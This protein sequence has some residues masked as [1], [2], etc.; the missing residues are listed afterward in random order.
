MG[1]LRFGHPEDKAAA[2]AFYRRQRS[3]DSLVANIVR[4]YMQY[5]L[6]DDWPTKSAPHCFYPKSF[7]RVPL[8]L[9]QSAAEQLQLIKTMPE[10]SRPTSP[11]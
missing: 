3:R 9:L 8:A 5:V 7:N 11:L 4:Y 1:P 10:F 6:M 2:E